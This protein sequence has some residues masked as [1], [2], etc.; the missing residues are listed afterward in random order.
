MVR[1]IKIGD[2]WWKVIGVYVNEGVERLLDELREILEKKEKDVRTI[3][4]GDFNARTGEEGGEIVEE[5]ERGEGTRR[6]SKDKKLNAEGR[7]LVNKIE[8]MGWTIWN[9]DT[10]GDEEGEWTY[11]GGRGESVIDYV[12]GEAWLKDEV[13]RMVVE[14]K[15][16]SDHQPV[17]VWV[18]IK[19]S[20]RKRARNENE[21][22]K[23][24]RIRWTEEGSQ[25]LEEEMEKREEREKKVEE[26]WEE[27]KKLIGR[28]FKGIDGE[29]K[30]NGKRWWDEECREKKKRVYAGVLAERL[31][32]EV[33]KKGLM[34]NNQAGFRKGRGAIDNIYVLNY[35]VNK[36]LSKKG[37]KLMAFFVDLR[38]AF[39]MVDKGVLTRTMNERGVRKE[40]VE[41]CMELY[42]ETRIRVRKGEKVGKKFWVGRGVR[43]GCP[44]SPDLFNLLLV[45][46]EEKVKKGSW[47]GVKIKGEKIYSL[48]YADDIV[49]LAEEEEG[50]RNLMKRFE[51][52]IKEKGLELNAEKSKVLRFRKGGGRDKKTEWY[53]R[54][55]KIEEVKK[56]KYLGFIFQR[57]GRLDEQIKDRVKKGAAV[58]GQV[59][60][61]GKR[62]F[63][64]DWG[65]RVWLFDTLIWSVDQKDCLKKKYHQD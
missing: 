41:K 17:V 40:L 48:A 32:M 47:G 50:M 59:W 64:R 6:K 19:G 15:V 24:K 45:D 60:G 12:I 52:Y 7:K 37:G 21:G 33:E 44:L 51:K 61:I 1:N 65:R 62:R 9:G 55:E 18:R 49:L 54:G 58:M 39:D 35:L 36:N 8:E 25:Q 53:W 31:R 28:V 30:K 42:K 13:E 11:T 63:G 22:K 38:S 57:N 5:E 10:R 46:L 16:D 43:Q 27:M 34:G 14:D 23:M 3:L 26:E 4:G 2:G 20:K 29:E 56:F